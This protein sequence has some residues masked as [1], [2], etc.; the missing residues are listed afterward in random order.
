LSNA[1]SIDTIP[2][3]PLA[4][5]SKAWMEASAALPIGW[6]LDG[7]TCAS[8]GLA[9]DL[10]S[11]RWLAR[12]IGPKSEALA[13]EGQGAIA[14]LGALDAGARGAPGVDERVRHRGLVLI[15]PLVVVAL[16]GLWLPG[17]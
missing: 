13:A 15:A 14:A 9:P 8:R 17:A 7:I 16:F 3:M 5:L 11:E 6:R 10:R 12:A 4:G 2:G 1:C